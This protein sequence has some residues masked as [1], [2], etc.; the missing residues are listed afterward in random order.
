MSSLAEASLRYAFRMASW[1]FQRTKKPPVLRRIQFRLFSARGVFG[2]PGLHAPRDFQTL[3]HT[4]KHR[5]AEASDGIFLQM[6]SCG[7]EGSEGAA[8]CCCRST[9]GPRASS[10]LK[11]INFAVDLQRAVQSVG[12]RQPLSQRETLVS[13]VAHES[14]FLYR[15]IHRRS[16]ERQPMRAWL[17]YRAT[18]MNLTPTLTFTKLSAGG[19][20]ARLICDF[21]AVPCLPAGFSRTPVPWLV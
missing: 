9:H 14:R 17:S 20:L 19:A 1:P 12:R 16:G 5:L 3:L 11:A 4:A 21:R 13:C 10:P 18:W 8:V 6:R 2:V 15:C 7:A